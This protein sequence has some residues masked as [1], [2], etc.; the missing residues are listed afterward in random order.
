[1]T[2]D[3][4]DSPA[5]YDPSLNDPPECGICG[6]PMELECDDWD[7]DTRHASYSWVCRNPECGAD[8]D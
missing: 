2:R 7:E 8:H 6:F 4:S 5:F 1:M 3:P